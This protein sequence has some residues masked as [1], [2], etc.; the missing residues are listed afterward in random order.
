MKNK[1]Y[2][3]WGKLVIVLLATVASVFKWFGVLG[4]ASIAEIWEVAGFAYGIMLGT[5]D[6]NIIVD[7]FRENKGKEVR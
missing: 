4:N 2:S 3:K 7:G 5:M 1:D 6:F